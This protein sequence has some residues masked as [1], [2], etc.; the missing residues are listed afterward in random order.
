MSPG[1]PEGHQRD[2]EERGPRHEAKEPGGAD[3][4]AVGRERRLPDRRDRPAADGPDFKRG[5]PTGMEIYEL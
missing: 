1:Y 2:A 4:T 5:Q 3:P